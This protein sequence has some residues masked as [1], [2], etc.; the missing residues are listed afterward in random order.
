MTRDDGKNCACPP[1][2]C[3]PHLCP[4]Y[5]DC[6]GVAQVANVDECRTALSKVESGG[7]KSTP[8]GVISFLAA[9]DAVSIRAFIHDQIGQ[10]ENMSGAE[11]FQNIA[12][13]LK[14]AL[15]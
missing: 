13:K 11:S 10:S 7:L 8:D 9:L 1:H 4:W 6:P 15:N 14:S 5:R 12:R 3:P 2:L